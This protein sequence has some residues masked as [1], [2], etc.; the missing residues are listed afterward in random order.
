MKRK[1]EAILYL[2]F[3]VIVLVMAIMIKLG[4]LKLNKFEGKED[5]FAIT[6]IILCIIC[7]IYGVYSLR[8]ELKKDKS[9]FTDIKKC[10]DDYI[11]SKLS[12]L[13]YDTISIDNNKNFYSIEIGYEKVDFSLSFHPL[14]VDFYLECKDWYV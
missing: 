13:E 7:F 14:F 10:S 11:K 4:Y 1:T 9:S 12:C 2:V 3:D 6:L 8:T 5:I